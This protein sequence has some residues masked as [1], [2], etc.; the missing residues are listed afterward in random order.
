MRGI[1]WRRIGC[2]SLFGL[3]EGHCPPNPSI[4]EPQ[5]LAG[6]LNEYSQLLQRVDE[7]QGSPIGIQEQDENKYCC[8]RG[9]KYDIGQP[10]LFGEGRQRGDTDCKENAIANAPSNLRSALRR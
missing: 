6:V 8:P 9:R 10:D 3:K 4:P 2:F 7:E 1:G 5:F